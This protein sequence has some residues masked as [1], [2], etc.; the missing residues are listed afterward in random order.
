MNIKYSKKSVKY[1]NNADKAT[2]KRLKE[3]IEKLPS[4][5]IKKLKGAKDGYR[6]RVGDLRIL[7]AIDDDTVFIEDIKPRGQ[8]YR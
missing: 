5:D 7:F 3:A 1:I 2:K 4:G 6:L 8:A